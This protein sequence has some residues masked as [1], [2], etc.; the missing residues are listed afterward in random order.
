M[1][2]YVENNPV[3]YTDPSGLLLAAPTYNCTTTRIWGHWEDGN[4][5][6]TGYASFSYT[7]CQSAGG[8]GEIDEPAGGGGGSGEGNGNDEISEN[9]ANAIRS[10]GNGILDAVKDYLKNGKFIDINAKSPFGNGLIK[11]DSANSWIGRF[12]GIST[13]ESELRQRAV[14]PNTHAIAIRG[15]GNVP[16]G[17]TGDGIYFDSSKYD[18]HKDFQLKLHETVHMVFPRTLNRT[19]TNLDQELVDGLGLTL[20]SGLAG[21]TESASDRLSRFF[22]NDCNEDIR[23]GG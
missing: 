12:G 22:N 13:L 23:G 4:G 17:I 20:K 6:I 5:N 16:D 9:C 15:T 2:A 14:S 10:L 18:I 11:E 3:D 8:G 7:T 1:F 21:Q 19:G